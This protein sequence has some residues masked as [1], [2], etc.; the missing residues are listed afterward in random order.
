MQ[1]FLPAHP[2]RARGSHLTEVGRY[3]A[4]ISLRLQRTPVAAATADAVVSRAVRRA[5][6]RLGV[7]GRIF[8]GRATQRGVELR[9]A[10]EAAAAALVHGGVVVVVDALQAA[11]RVAVHGVGA[12]QGA[13]L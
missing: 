6:S 9:V 7:I 8:F 2:L 3:G 10:A 13:V 4:T 11:V 1:N 5:G 12:L